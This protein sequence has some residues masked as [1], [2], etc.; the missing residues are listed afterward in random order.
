M[1]FCANP[2]FDAPFHF[3]CLWHH[4]A[5]RLGEVVP[6]GSFKPVDT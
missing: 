6:V 5:L 1:G 4:L 2:I 3:L